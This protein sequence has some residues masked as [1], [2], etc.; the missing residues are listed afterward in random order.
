MITLSSDVKYPF[1]STDVAEPELAIPADIF[2]RL[3]TD[4]YRQR[5]GL[6]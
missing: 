6:T 3:G 2:L 5:N 4:K 1:G